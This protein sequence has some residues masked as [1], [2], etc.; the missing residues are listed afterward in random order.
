MSLNTKLGESSMEAKNV[1]NPLV[2]LAKL[3]RDQALDSESDHSKSVHSWD[4][5]KSRRR[6]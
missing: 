5:Q 6:E 2:L 3:H 1:V 4:M